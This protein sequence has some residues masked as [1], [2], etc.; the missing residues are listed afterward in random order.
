[1]TAVCY[2]LHPMHYGKCDAKDGS[3]EPC[4]CS[5]CDYLGEVHD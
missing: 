4:S 1:M 3:G 2:C 5:V